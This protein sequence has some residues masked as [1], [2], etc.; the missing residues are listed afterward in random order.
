ME[1]AQLSAEIAAKQ[2]K[3]LAKERLLNSKVFQKAMNVFNRTGQY[4][5]INIPT[6]NSIGALQI[7][8]SL[9][10]H[11]GSDSGHG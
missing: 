11:R 4:P 5:D 7:G 6:G 3:A 1:A 2:K 8:S 10:R 9:S